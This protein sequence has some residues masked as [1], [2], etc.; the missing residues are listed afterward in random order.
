V[1]V[2]GAEIEGYKND[3][4]REGLSAKTVSNHLIVPRQLLGFLAQEWG[5]LD[6]LPKVKWLKVRFSRRSRSWE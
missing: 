4:L 1:E 6:R 5:A 2:G 3:K